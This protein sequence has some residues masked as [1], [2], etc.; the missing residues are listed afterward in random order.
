MRTVMQLII[1]FLMIM[2]IAGC[3]YFEDTLS[4][5]TQSDLG[6]YPPPGYL[7]SWQDAF[8]TFDPDNWN[9]GL[10]SDI[11]EDHIIWNPTTGGKGLLNESYS[12]YITDEDVYIENGLMML[13]NQKRSFQGQHP[14]GQ[15]KYTSGWMNSMNK[16]IFNGTQKGVYIE[17]KAKFPSGLKV[18]PA[19]WMVTEEPHW[20]PEIDIWEYFGHYWN[21][22]DKMYMRYIY[23]LTEEEAWKKENHNDESKVINNFDQDY[24]CEVWHVF[25][26]QWTASE[27]IWSIDGDIVHTLKKSSI[28]DYWPDEA[29]SLVINNGVQ[30]NAK[31]EDTTWPN[32]LILDYIAVY[33]QQ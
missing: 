8:T 20:P 32:Y 26:F 28:P 25:G 21:G 13:R 29:F 22:D 17:I 14:T 5:Y 3:N 2:F 31:D 7:L 23:P 1:F 12:G 11:S 16:R 9:K 4:T 10:E 15:F 33:E 30:T 24:D 18:W 6:I 19:I 27:M